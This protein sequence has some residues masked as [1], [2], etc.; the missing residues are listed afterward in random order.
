M[1][2]VHRRS[3]EIPQ[4][5]CKKHMTIRADNLN[6]SRQQKGNMKTLGTIIEEVMD[7]LKPDYD[8]LRYALIAVNSLRH[9][10]SNAI[11]KMWGKEK[12]G[13][14]RHDLFGL[15]WEAKES[16]NRAH[17]ALNLPPKQWV[18]SAH[19][20]DTEE[21]QRFRKMAKGLLAK[22]TTRADTRPDRGMEEK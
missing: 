16:H 18:G 3:V 2:C 10:D 17:T 5:G 13:K 19:D 14:Y 1:S 15:E 12:D 11:M 6:H 9:F 7:G 8:D 20:P 22:V 21:C 4:V